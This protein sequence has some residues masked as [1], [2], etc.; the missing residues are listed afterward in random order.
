MILRW[1][2][3]MTADTPEP[4]DVAIRFFENHPADIGVSCI[5]LG[6]PKDGSNAF[7][8]FSTKSGNVFTL[9]DQEAVVQNETSSI[10]RAG[11]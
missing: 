4:S 8:G 11:L 7:I 10:F 6:G 1:K 5:D 2:N 3:L 9:G